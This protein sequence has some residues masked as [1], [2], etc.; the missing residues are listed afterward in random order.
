MTIEEFDAL[1]QRRM[2]A[3]PWGKPIVVR[4]FDSGPHYACRL[5][6][7]RVGLYG[8]DVRDLPTNLA[9]VERHIAVTHVIH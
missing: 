3:I 1:I 9:E 5:C 4:L 2:P 8:G 6:L 7:A